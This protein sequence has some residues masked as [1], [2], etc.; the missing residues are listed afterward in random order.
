ML[1]A[2]GLTLAWTGDSSAVM[3]LHEFVGDSNGDRFG[4]SVSGG[5]EINNDGVP[6]VIVGA[7]LDDNNGSISGMVRVFS[8]AT[9]GILYSI[10]GDGVGDVLGQSVAGVSDV[11]GDAHDDFIIGAVGDD[12]NGINSG[13]VRIISGRTGGVLF[14]FDG[15]ATKDRLGQSVADAGDVNGDLVNDVIAGA[16]Q[17]D[18]FNPGTGYARAYS[19]ADGSTLYTFVGDAQG[20]I[21]G[22]CVGGVGDINGDDRSDVVVGAERFEQGVPGY[23]RVF[24]GMDGSVLHEFTG[25]ANDD[26][27]G[28]ACA[29]VGDVNKDGVPDLIVGAIQRNTGGGYARV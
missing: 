29:G 28:R 6:D 15:D 13:S 1:V 24:S 23:A 21:F 5:V 3:V 19:G 4:N 16:V 12:N 20:D 9:G 27:F 25:T 26:E 22:E 11:D 17:D 18:F 14:L 2:V 10:D 8:G 7:S